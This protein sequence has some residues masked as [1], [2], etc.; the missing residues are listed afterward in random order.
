VLNHIIQSAY[1]TLYA[2]MDTC[3]SRVDIVALYDRVIAG[4]TDDHAVRGLSNLILLKLITVAPEET[5]RRLDELTDKFRIVLAEKAKENAV[6]HEVEKIDESKK[7]VVKISLE[8]NRAFPGEAGTG[9]PGQS[10]GR[11]KWSNYLDDMRKEQLALVKD[12][13]KEM[14][15]KERA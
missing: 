9:L 12:L 5:I 13:E 14:K 4:V 11:P 7:G 6:R 2:V 10:T 1:E 15:E 8:L 3:P